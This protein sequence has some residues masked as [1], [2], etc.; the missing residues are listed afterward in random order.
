M[1]HRILPL[2]M[3]GA[4]L[5]AHT[6][7]RARG[8][9]PSN[10]TAFFVDPRGDDKAAGTMEKPFKSPARARDAVRELKRRGG[11]KLA[12][13]VTIN[14]RA[15]TYFLSEP[16]VLT[17]EDGGTERAP[18]TYAA[19][20]KEKPVLSGGRAVTGWSK[21]KLGDREVWT[22]RLERKD[23][24][25]LRSL[26]VQGA[27]ATRAR[28]P[29]KGYLAVDHVS[30][31]TGEWTK[32]VGSFQFKGTDLKAWPK[33][34]EDG[35]EA[36][37]MSRWVESRLPITAVEEASRS[38]KFGQK[39]VFVLQK[40]DLYWVEG[41][42]SFLDQPGEWH[43]DRATGVLSYVP[44]DGEDMAKAEAIVPAVAQ[45]L[46]LEGKPESGSFIGHV[47]FRGLGFSH[48]DWGQGWPGHDAKASGF[49]QA[50][51]GVP[52][53][54]HADGA[55][56]CVF[57]ACDFSHVGTYALRLA[58]G[59]QNNR[60]TF[61][62]MT[63]L[64]A[65]GVRIGETEVREKPADETFGNEV[66]D[67][68]IIDGGNLF[69][70]AVGVWIGQ[71]RD[72]RI[73]HNEIAD[74]YYTALS[75]GWTWGYGKS[76]AGGNVIGHNHVHHIGQP[77]DETKPILSD[78]GGIYTL[79][80][81]GGTVIR[82]NR[83]HDINGLKYGGWGIYY[84][85]GSSNVVSENNVIYRTTHGGF[86]QHYGRDNV[87]RNNIIAFGRDYQVQRTRPEAHRSFTF[88][89][90]ILYWEKGDAVAGGWDNYN[91][92]FDK[93]VYWRTDGAKEFRLG[94]LPLEGWR[95]K[96]LD[97]HSVVSDPKFV[98]VAGD[99]FNLKPDS[100]AIAAGFVP[101][102]QSAVGPRK[103]AGGGE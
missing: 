52:A 85:E 78:M 37:V 28:H 47:T 70:S 3:L 6:S 69:P 90:N 95:G 66:S 34:V 21:G 19:Y 32:G 49:S 44:R 97:V 5:V 13:P 39:S 55:R 100:P 22:A 74:L 91:V 82:N 51:S 29:D 38:V 40:D 26:W 76:G 35:A 103:R 9:E 98:N 93:N 50:A 45:V 87:F 83:F 48:C 4:M 18:V 15:G 2:V 73:V 1:S 77:S 81:Q 84:D 89:R 62:T 80:I 54:V 92:A 46:R 60:V 59:C 27:R 14:F 36:V 24:P 61:C 101:F 63:D 23:A 10:A 86:H 8:D 31:A 17:P 16:L 56:H 11:G 96:G 33:L 53:A 67:C 72:N 58:R 88:E 12:G 94:N 57:D 68:R 41:N 30:E 99:D 20:Q 42:A 79:G 7:S 64:G 43:F 75:I 102:D 25:P 71:S 65:G